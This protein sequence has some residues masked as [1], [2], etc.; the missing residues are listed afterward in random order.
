MSEGDQGSSNRVTLDE[1][2]LAVRNH[3]MP[4]E[5]LRYD[6]TPVGLHYLLIHYDIPEV[7]TATWRL[8]VSGRVRRPQLLSIQDLRALPP[9][10]VAVTMECAGNGRARLNP[11]PIS[12]PWLS[13]AIGTAEWTGVPLCVVLEASTIEADAVAVSFSGLD[14][15]IEDGVPQR[16]ARGLSLTE[17]LSPDTLLVYAINGTPLPPQHGFPLRLIVPG[18][19]GMT[20]VKWLSEVTVLAEPFDGFQQHAY[21]VMA[22]EGDVGEPVTRMLPRALILPPGIPEFMTRARHLAPGVHT[23]RGRAWSG[24]GRIAQVELS[25]DGGAAWLDTEVRHHQSDFAW[26]SWSYSWQCSPGRYTLC[27]RARDEHGNVQPV[28]PSWNLNGY[29]N[30]AVERI[31]VVVNEVLGGPG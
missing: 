31:D 14:A 10:T 25:T 30:N 9:R 8:S 2:Q 20:N 1:L 24:W 23:L 27:A 22:C 15:G 21:R 28:Q 19:Y 26:C 4:L 29:E 5:A 17:A 3:G 11:R 13:E 6:V 12:Q 18:W 16:Y 7:D